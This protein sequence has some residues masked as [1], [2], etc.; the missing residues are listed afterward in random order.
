M[1]ILAVKENFVKV[2]ICVDIAIHDKND[3]NPHCHILLT[4]RPLNED[5]TWGAKSKKEYILDKNDEYG[6]DI[7][8]E[9]DKAIKR[10]D[11]PSVIAQLKNPKSKRKER[12]STNKRQ[13][14]NIPSEKGNCATRV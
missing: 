10:V 8:I 11:K 1:S 6:I 14:K 12:N 5:K 3:G 7:S 2:G 9:I 4:M 13:K